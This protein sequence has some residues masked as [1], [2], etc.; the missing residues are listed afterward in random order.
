VT[1]RGRA[2]AE[3]A[4]RVVEAADREF[5]DAAGGDGDSERLVAMLRRLAGPNLRAQ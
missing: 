1:R 5:F 3:R 2:L 4:V